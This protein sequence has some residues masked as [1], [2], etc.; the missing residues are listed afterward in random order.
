MSYETYLRKALEIA[1]SIV[2]EPIYGHG[3]SSGGESKSFANYWILH[4]GFWR[5]IGLWIDTENWID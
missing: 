5:D 4:T 1:R 3:D 2:Y